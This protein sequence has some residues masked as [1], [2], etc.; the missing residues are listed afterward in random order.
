MSKTAL[1]IN[2]ILFTDP[3]NILSSFSGTNKNLTSTLNLS[4][5]FEG[6]PIP[7]IHWY[8]SFNSTEEELE[9]KN[10]RR[11][12]ISHEL[13]EYGNSF[14]ELVIDDLRKSDKG[15]YKCVGSN[16]VENLIG[17]VDSVKGIITMCG[18]VII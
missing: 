2:K 3:A 12:N 9:L 7:Q 13:D 15:S 16:G 14:S 6:I 17:A 8:V 10:S 11:I 4:C 5:T 18:K 1:L